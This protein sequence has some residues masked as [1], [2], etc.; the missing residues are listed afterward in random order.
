MHVTLATKTLEAIE[1]AIKADQGSA[2][3]GFLGKVIPHMGDAYRT[4][5]DEGF[6]SHMGASLIGGECA[7]K[8]WYGFRWSTK[9]TFGGRTLRLFNRGH[10]EEARMI[11][12]LLTIGCQVY[13]QDENGNQFRIHDAGGHFG[14]SGDGVA[15]GLPDLAPG[16]A[17]LL[18]FKTHNDASFKKL[19]LPEGVRGCKFEHYVQ[20]Q[21]YMRKMGLACALYLA[22]N[23]NNDELYGEI[24]TLNVEIAEQFIDRARKIIPMQVAPARMSE[25]P[26]FFQCKWCDDHPVC[27]RKAMP[28]RNCRT[29]EFARPNTEDGKWWCD[30]KQRQMELLFPAT[31]PFNEDFTLSKDRQL[32]SCEHYKVNSSFG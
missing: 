28:V 30:N 24:V 15:V 19:L 32:A 6:R 11:A 10:L 4:G 12:C 5:P 17:A 14:G 27:H 8:I 9:P 13:Q 31:N 3:R 16:T 29:C 22:V 18:E 21:T 20:M 2:F 23:K 26:G 25:S 1:A 7:R